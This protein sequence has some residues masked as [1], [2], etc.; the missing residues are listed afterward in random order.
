MKDTPRVMLGSAINEHKGYILDKWVDRL[1]ELTYP[2]LEMLLVDNTRSDRYLDRARDLTLGMPLR[3]VK[4][5][6]CSDFRG[7]MVTTH[8]KLREEFLKSKA[9]YLFIL[10]QDV[11]PPIDL[12]LIHI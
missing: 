1:K 2:K 6:W 10:D 5:V 7:R 8:N 11:I 3:I 9:D 12:S 4:D